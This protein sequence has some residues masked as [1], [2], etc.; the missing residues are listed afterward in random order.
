MNKSNL[1]TTILVISIFFFLFGLCGFLYTLFFGLESWGITNETVWGIEIVNFVFWIGNSHA[2]TLISAILYLLRQDWRSS[3]HRIAETITLI[4]I[5][6]AASFPF[7]HLGRQWFFYW[8]LPI[9]N[10]TTTWANFKS[11]LI[12]DVIAVISYAFLSFFFWFLGILPDHK[13]FKFS[14]K[15]LLGIN[16]KLFFLSIWTGSENNWK[17]YWWTYHL[18]AGVLTFVVVS[19]HSIV[20]YDFSVAF[21][22]QWHSTMLPV[23]FVIGAIYSGIALVLLCT[24]ILNSISS[25][26]DQIST[27]VRQKL[28]KLLLSFSLILYYFYLV[29]YFFSFYGQNPK[30]IFVYNLRFQNEY[31]V[32]FLITV[33]LTF[34]LPQLFWSKRILVSKTAQVLVS[35]SALFGMWFERYLLI[36]PILSSDLITGKT[37]TYAPTIVDLSLTL[38]SFGFFVLAF[39]LI[40]KLI[41]MVP[42]YES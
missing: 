25:F 26:G 21:L 30:E 7:I 18:L 3:I 28:A 32:M 33:C 9:P 40:G 39:Y 36:I 35:L 23:F 31:L 29:E 5:A 16:F 27:E 38:G 15:K 12:W 1:R 37:Y 19:V 13:H 4:C 20:A 41:P 42:K 6:L 11:P 24:T 17:E 22:P 8:M 10:E 2:G 14:K 34:I